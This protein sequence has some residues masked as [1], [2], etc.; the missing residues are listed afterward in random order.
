MSISDSEKLLQS[1]FTFISKVVEEKNLDKK[2]IMLADMGRTLVNADRCTVWLIDKENSKLWTKVA[3]GLEKTIIE[4]GHGIAGTVAL[5]GEKVVINDAYND[6]RFD[7]TVDKKTGY[8]TKSILAIPF[9]DVD[10]NIIGVFQ[11]INKMSEDAVFTEMDLQR[12]MLAASYT[13]KELSSMLLQLEIENTQKEIIF[14]MAEVGESRSK[15]TGNHVK[16]VAA[17]SEVLAIGIGLKKSEAELLKMASPM[18]DIRKV[19]I[20][21]AVLL[22]PGKL[23]DE[24][25]EIMRSHCEKGFKMLGHSKRRILKAAAIVA[26]EHHEKWNGTG[27][28]RKLKGEEIHIFGRITALADVFDALGSDR[29][30]KKACELDRIFELFK[31]EKGEHFDPDVVDTFFENIDEILK[32]RDFYRDKF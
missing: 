7:K 19:A 9:E 29:V 15:E 17:Y 27:Y 23:N 10:G 12:L 4:L 3:H 26:Y 8:T 32:I 22:K 1:I 2:L 6:P 14:T 21:D 30:Y 20:P 25:W 18:H 28:P 24:E 31:E 13:G 11:A 5:T 16:R